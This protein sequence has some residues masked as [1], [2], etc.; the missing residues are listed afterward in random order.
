MAG[1]KPQANLPFAAAYIAQKKGYFADQRLDVQIR[2]SQG[3]QHIPL[4]AAGEIDVATADASDVLKRNAAGIPLT[5]VVLFGQVG[6]QG[7]ISLESS[8]I[9]SPSDWQGKRFGYKISLPPAYR[10]ILETEGIDR[11]R[12]E[13]ISVGFDPRILSQGQ[14]DVLA[15]FKSNEPDTLTRMGFPVTLFDPI[16]F[17]VPQLG[18]T[19]IVNS[20]RLNEQGDMIQRFVKATLRGVKFAIENEEEALDII[21]EF[22]PLEEREHQRFML[23]QELGDARSAITNERGIGAMTAGQWQNLHDHLIEYEAIPNS[24]DVTT[25]FD[26]RFV[27]TAYDGPELRWP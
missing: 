1:F 27:S 24:V 10:A 3:G 26:D 12:I 25:V 22:A 15:V 21:L 8:G 7:F 2:H 14:V 6:Q 5:A 9:K 11:S 17:G 4:L 13:E 23:R 20:D 18:L 19:Y 16:D